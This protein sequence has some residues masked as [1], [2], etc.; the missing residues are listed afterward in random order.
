[1]DQKDHIEDD[2]MGSMKV[3]KTIGTLNKILSKS[4]N[5]ESTVSDGVE[6]SCQESG[7]RI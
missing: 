4:K 6:T 2:I 7:H 1:M 5:M 3:V